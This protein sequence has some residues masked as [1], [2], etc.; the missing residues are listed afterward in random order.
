MTLRAGSYDRSLPRWTGILREDSY[1]AAVCTRRNHDNQRE[2]TACTREAKR[3]LAST[4]RLPDGWR[5]YIP[6]VD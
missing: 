3:V 6:E 4:G 1:P 2:A 5:D